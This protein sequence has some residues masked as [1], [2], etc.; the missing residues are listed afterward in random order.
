MPRRWLLLRRPLWLAACLALAACRS[1]GPPDGAATGAWLP[2]RAFFRDPVIEHLALSPDGERIAGIVRP[3]GV[4]VLFEK[5]LRGREKRALGKLSE[6]GA[7]IQNLGWA[8]DA[9]LVVVYARE[10]EGARGPARELSVLTARLE[11]W[12]SRDRDPV[13]RFP[14]HPEL[15]DGVLHWLPDDPGYILLNRWESDAE[16]ASVRRARVRDGVQNVVEPS[17]PWV[18]RWFVDSNG[19]VR[20]ARGYDPETTSEVYY[21]RPSADVAFELLSAGD[22]MQESYLVFAGFDVDPNRIY[23]YSSTESG[24]IGLFEYDLARR[25]LGRALYTDPDADAGALVHS[26]VDGR[27]WAVEVEADRP[28]LRFFDEE[29]RREQASIDLTFPGTTNRIVGASLDGTTAI[30]RVSG[31]AQPPEYYIYDRTN[32]AMVAQPAPYP[33]LEDALLAPMQPVRFTARDGLSVPGYLSVPP[34]AEPRKLPAI[35]IVHDGPSERVHWDFDATVQFLVSR[36]FAVF[37]PN[38][39]GSSGYGREY[40]RLGY[41]EWGGAMQGDV[42]DAARWLVSEGIADPGRIGVYGRGYG[43]Y[44]ALLALATAPDLFRAGASFGAVTDRVALFENPDLYVSRDPNHPVAGATPQDL[45]QLA[46]TSPARLAEHIRAPVL[47]AHGSRDPVVDASQLEAMQSA[48]EAAGRDVESRVYRDQT[49]E[50]IDERYRIEF[51][52]ELAAFFERHLN[53]QVPL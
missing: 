21:A 43:G 26:F 44:A 42:S 25:Q 19:A 49:H 40:E 36:G 9:A 47:L 22:L 37:Q 20:A 38:F 52:E 12:R 7:V 11:R 3:R 30:V 24:R 46:A 2:A 13:W 32:R 8:G 28:G 18:S 27:L 6:R 16:G 23:V 33:E 14:A 50:L 5:V 34:G 1:A 48:L 10:G 51:H 39:R 41:R 29:A 31:D 4:P 53:A 15:A 45:E 17:R 35:V